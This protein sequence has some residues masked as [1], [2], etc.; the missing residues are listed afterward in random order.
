S[1]LSRLPAYVSLSNTTS[2][3]SGCF[4][5]IR[6]TNALPIKPAPPATKMFFIIAPSIPRGRQNETLY[7]QRN[8]VFVVARRHEIRCVSN[9]RRGIAHCHADPG[10][11]D[12][13][14]IVG[15]VAE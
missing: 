3:Y 8:A 1:R 15:V 5:T 10:H 6:R 7:R 4:A 2:L 9:V 11:L 14:Q 12:H 13:R